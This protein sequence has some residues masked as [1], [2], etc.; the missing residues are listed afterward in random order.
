MRKFFGFA[1]LAVI[2]LIGWNY[3]Q[4]AWHLGAPDF[5][6]GWHCPPGTFLKTEWVKVP[7]PYPNESYMWH[8]WRDVGGCASSITITAG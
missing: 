3:V 5:Y 2:A 1:V 6:R 7:D 4:S 8:G